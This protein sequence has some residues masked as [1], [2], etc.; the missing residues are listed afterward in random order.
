MLV[1]D[2]CINLRVV[3]SEL[4][5]EYLIALNSILFEQLKLALELPL[6]LQPLLRPTNVNHLPVELHS[7]HFIDCL[8]KQEQH[9]ECQTPESSPRAAALPA[10]R[11]THSTF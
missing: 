11:R 6:A 8:G 1:K 5:T 9:P 7:V 3:A 4:G 10:P 2:P